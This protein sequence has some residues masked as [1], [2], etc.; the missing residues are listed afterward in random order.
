MRGRAGSDVLHPIGWDSFGL[1][2]EN[3]ALARNMDPRDWTYANIEVQAEAFRR[4]GISVDWRTR[5]H[6]SDPELLPLDPVA[7]PEALRARAG[8][9]QV[10]AGQLVPQGP[11]RAGERA[12]DPGPV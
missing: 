3:A 5:L 10:G 7:V 11:D 9:S 6:T 4:F 8:L 12:G 2:A 1:P